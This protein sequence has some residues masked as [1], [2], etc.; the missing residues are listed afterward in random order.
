MERASSEAT[1][2]RV[3]GGKL[4]MNTR[5]QKV[6]VAVYSADPVSSAGLRE[7]VRQSADLELSED[8]PQ[9]RIMAD[10]GRLVPV[11]QNLNEYAGTDVAQI[12]VGELP[13]G[14][15]VHAVDAGLRAVLTPRRTDA[16][17]LARAVRTVAAGGTLLPPLLVTELVRHINRVQHE[18]LVPNGLSTSG[19]TTRE[20]DV[21]RLLAEGY[22]TAEIATKLNWAQRTVKNIVRVLNSR[23]DLRNR[24]HLVAWAVRN[25]LI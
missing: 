13:S 6:K 23:L 10:E 11:L 25:G 3:W 19:L 24:T 2:R 7:Y 9:V 18:V 1:G 22:D 17:S 12:L 14:A 5:V 20:L 21:L 16:T 8:A 4:L 15:V